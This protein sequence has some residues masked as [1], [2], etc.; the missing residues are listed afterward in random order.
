MPGR[1]MFGYGVK[2]N[3][4][5]QDLGAQEGWLSLLEAVRGLGGLCLNWESNGT[6]RG[7]VNDG[8]IG[9]GGGGG[10][11]GTQEGYVRSLFGNYTV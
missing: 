3:P 5:G 7:Q 1:L 10:G 6:Q 9:G 4:G 8:W 2:R 11:G